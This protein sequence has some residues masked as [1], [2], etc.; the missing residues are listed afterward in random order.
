LKKCSLSQL[1]L[2]RA[3]LGM[4]KIGGSNSHCLLFYCFSVI[5]SLSGFAGWRHVA[6]NP[7]FE[8]LKKLK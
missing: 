3:S 1:N 2:L 4:I 6:R 8:R 5:S 7:A